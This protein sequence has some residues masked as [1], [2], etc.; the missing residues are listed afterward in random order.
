MLAPPALIPFCCLRFPKLPFSAGMNFMA[1]WQSLTSSAAA[2][3]CNYSLW[4]E[5]ADPVLLWVLSNPHPHNL[6]LLLMKNGGGG[7]SYK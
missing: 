3:F 7:T 2:I 4:E 1:L 5:E 6:I